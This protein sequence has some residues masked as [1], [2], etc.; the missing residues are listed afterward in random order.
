MGRIGM[1]SIH[2]PDYFLCSGGDSW[3]QPGYLV[4]GARQSV[5]ANDLHKT[6]V[7]RWVEGEIVLGVR[8]V[9]FLLVGYS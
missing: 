2:I 5:G 8:G 6:V 4:R 1:I 7:G 3:V 9:S